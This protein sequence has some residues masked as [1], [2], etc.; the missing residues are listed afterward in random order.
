MSFG[1]GTYLLALFAGSLST[2]S[3][4]VLPILPILLTSAVNAHRRGIWMLALGLAL[5]FTLIGMFIATLGLSLGLEAS[6]LHLVGAVLLI[7]FGVILLSS[8]LQQR[9]A[10]ASAG[11]GNSG[12][13]LLNRLN[14]EGLKGQFTIGLLLGLVWSPCTGPTLG[15]VTTVA[16]QGQQLSQV[17][18]L[19]LLF[20]LGAG[21]PLI[22]L[23]SVSR[24]AMPRLKLRLVRTGAFGKRLLGVA[25]VLL[26]LAII[27]GLD[28][29]MEAFLADHSPAWLTELTTLY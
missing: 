1:P 2:L 22:L 17:A 12:T 25:L 3:P 24:S 14:P 10:V 26:G 13:N 16:A 9:F 23:G 27:T 20:G 28:K 8:T 18:L 19:M 21:L 7:A 29:P 11:V 15:A 4:C 5:S 6:H